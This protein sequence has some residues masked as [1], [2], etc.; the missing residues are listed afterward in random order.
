MADPQSAQVGGTHYHGARL[1]DRSIRNIV[2]GRELQPW[3]VWEA[4]GLDPWCASAVAY[5]LRAGRKGPAR[6]DIAKARHYLDEMLAQ[7]DEAE[8]TTTRATTGAK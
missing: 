6:E 4:F 1:S 8:P 5:L 2:T 7:L 3:H